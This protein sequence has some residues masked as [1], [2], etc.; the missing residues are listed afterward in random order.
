MI[1]SKN[2]IQHFNSFWSGFTIFMWQIWL[3]FNSFRSISLFS[4]VFRRNV[5]LRKIW[6]LHI[7]APLEVS[8]TITAG[9]L[10]VLQL[11]LSTLVLEAVMYFDILTYDIFSLAYVACRQ[12]NCYQSVSCNAGRVLMHCFENKSR[13]R[14]NFNR[15]YTT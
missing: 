5:S 9:D 7:F 4:L 14:I 12:Q 10:I 1:I 13:L 8:L 3:F 11:L 6:Y 2:E 15:C